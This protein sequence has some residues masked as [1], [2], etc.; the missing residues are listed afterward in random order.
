[1]SA[2][3][4]IALSI[5][6]SAWILPV[7]FVFCIVDGFIPVLPSE[8]LIIALAA[9]AVSGQ[10][11]PNLIALFVLGALGAW[12][13]DQCAFWIGRWID[14]TRFRFY[15]RPRVTAV[16]DY[17]R[18]T[19]NKRGASVIFSARYVPIG[20]VAVNMTAGTLHYPYRRFMLIGVGAGLIWSAY[21]IA[22]GTV[23]AL[24]IN[25]GPILNAAVGVVG[26]LFIGIVVDFLVARRRR[27]AEQRAEQA[28]GFE[29]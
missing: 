9:F 22:I 4:S 10:P 15:R 16:F 1:M 11:A 12:I 19:L 7:V 28:N 13:G 3:E 14:V 27:A 23:S 26:G 18:R 29:V 21:S 24:W 2:I 17:A 25:G 6:G 5:S 8:T 20:R